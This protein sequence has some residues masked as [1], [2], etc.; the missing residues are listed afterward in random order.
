MGRRV[1]APLRWIGASFRR[2][3]ILAS[4]LVAVVFVVAV[5][6]WPYQ[7]R[8]GTYS[9]ATLRTLDGEMT[10]D[11]LEAV[12]Q[13]L[14]LDNVYHIRLGNRIYVR[15]LVAIEPDG[16]LDLHGDILDAQLHA[17]ASL[18]E[19]LDGDSLIGRELNGRIYAPPAWLA[20]LY[21]QD[22]S[23]VFGRDCTFIR[24][25]A[26]GERPPPGYEPEP[27]WL[28]RAPKATPP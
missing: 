14:W 16:D 15:L 2:R 11:F 23:L 21:E 6:L 28:D 19:P 26:F 25:V 13:S 20:A 12:D 27:S 4:L 9:S 8:C 24:A 3:P 5:P 1:T 18:V 22:H 10:P 7:P 17:V